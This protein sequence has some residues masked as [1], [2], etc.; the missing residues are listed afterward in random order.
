MPQTTPKVYHWA[1]S[2]LFYYFLAILV[3]APLPLG[4]NRDWSTALLAAL[5]L[6]GLVWGAALL[7]LHHL[8]VT[9]TLRKAW[10]ALASL[11]AVQIWV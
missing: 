2:A 5:L 9:P 8:S 6:A 11:V 3:W 7:A 1:N 4:S 10:P